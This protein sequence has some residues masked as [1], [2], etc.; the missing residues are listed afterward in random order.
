MLQTLREKPVVK[1]LVLSAVL[2]VMVLGIGIGAASVLTDLL[3]GR[4]SSAS[5]PNAPWAM[6][7]GSET[8]SPEAFNA[9]LR[10]I[11]RQYEQMGMT[12]TPDFQNR[13]RFEAV[14]SILRRTL[15]TNEARKSGLTVTDREVADRIV[16]MP[17]LQRDGQFIGRDAYQR[18]LAANDMSVG[19]FEEGIREGL[20][21]EKW[22][23]LVGAGAV[24]TDHEIDT[25]LAKRNQKVRFDYVMV[26]ASKFAPTS[27]VSDA[28]VKS[29]Y[30]AHPDRYQR[31]E[32]RRARY[33][34]VDPKASESQIPAPSADEIKKAY[35]ADK[36]H[37]PG[38][39]AEAQAQVRRQLVYQKSV[40]EADRRAAQFRA[41]ITDPAGFDAAAAKA[42]FKVE[43]TGELK[44]DGDGGAL[45]PAFL[46]ALFA[47]APG[48]V[49]GPV[50]TLKGTAVFVAAT[51]QAAGRATVEEARKD[52]LADL[53]KEKGRE[54][55]LAA[56]KRAVAAS[57]S[58]LAKVAQ[59]L[60]STVQ[61]AP[62]ISKGEP[63][64]TIGY[65]PSVEAAAFSTEAGAVA[66]PVTTSGGSIVVLKVVEKKAPDPGTLASSRDAIMRELQ[67]SREM[68]LVSSILEAALKRTEFKTNEE[69]FRQF[70][71]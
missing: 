52:V 2:V 16:A 71:S 34:L 68:A 1:K 67:K 29:Y 58:D 66:Q 40:A 37:F 12:E 23:S 27:S 60:S 18:M 43:D 9:E 46:D 55:A 45:G 56:A 20:L 5:V 15:E 42:G 7:I 21:N 47:A 54:A 53:S 33:V 64:P 44:R 41:T 22:E 57:G 14:Q 38:S 10:R 70:G 19:R 17:E 49:T 48:T 35:E 32:S 36:T 51:A 50:T 26:D 65:D 31:A 63:V 69:F 6:K 24:V 4:N 28:D 61:N 13:V 30:E 3:T 39:L 62:M 25:E 8:I 59:A 11:S